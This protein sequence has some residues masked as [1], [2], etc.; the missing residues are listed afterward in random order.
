MSHK[1]HK[2]RQVCNSWY[3]QLWFRVLLVVV[4]VDMII[5][6]GTLAVDIDIISFTLSI[7]MWLRIVGGVAYILVALFI[8]HYALSYQQMKRDL[9]FVCQHCGH[10]N[11]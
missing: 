11:N 6:G 10:A 7:P 8:I 3:H 2:R 5:L 4:G 1:H 9:H